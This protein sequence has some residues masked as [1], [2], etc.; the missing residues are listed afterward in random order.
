MNLVSPFEV[1][2]IDC[3]VVTSS[4]AKQILEY[5]VS[6]MIKI[7]QDHDGA[8]LAAPQVGIKKRFFVMKL[9]GEWKTFFNPLLV[10]V[11]STK[12][13]DREGCLNYKDGKDF[14]EVRRF[15]RIM[16]VYEEWSER[17]ET[18]VKRKGIFF[19]FDARVIQHEVD[20]LNGKTI[21]V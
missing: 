11:D 17:K 20:H 16:L 21:F 12:I 5:D 7:V 13:R 14:K 18:L 4:D 19:D 1:E 10:K 6:D 3:K 8:G 2:Y 15:K 9:N